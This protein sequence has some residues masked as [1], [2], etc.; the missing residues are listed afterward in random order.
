MLKKSLFIL[1]LFFLT[2]CKQKNNEKSPVIATENI[3]ETD[4]ATGFDIRK[5]K[6]YN[7]ITLNTPWKNALK[8][9][10]YLLIDNDAK[11]PKSIVYDEL[12]RVP[13]NKLVVTSTTHIPALESLGVLDKLVGF[14]NTN[15]ISS[16]AARELVKN[17]GIKELGKNESLNLEVLVD[18]NPDVVV[19][20]GIDGSNKALN[21]IKKSGIPVLYN[22]EWLEQHALGR[23]EW[24]KFFGFLFKK[25][26]EANEI[27]NTIKKEYNDAK[28]LAKK[29]V[30][31]PRVLSGMP[32][33]DTWYL[34]YGDSWAAQFI[35]D[36]N[37]S[38]LWSDKNGKGS[39]ALNFESVLEKAKD[40]DY[41]IAIGNYETKKQLLDSNSHYEQ[42]KMFQENTIYISNTKGATGGLLFYE[43]AP[44]RPDLI[45]KDLIKIFH[46]E[47]L[48][49]YNLNFYTQLN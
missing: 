24:I 7:I 21:N 49:K 4:F 15:Y 44:T 9:L 2:N 37:A 3:I 11:I 20:F 29:A 41:W 19:G 10:K 39:L 32:Y 36:A 16:L 8:P 43:L 48:P 33:K 14:P 28:K 38:Y 46:P 17:G 31:Q 5:E 30:I 42:F 35:N 13:V 45:L 6:G 23:A 25:E 22:S 34:P 27:F 47:L 12:I 18:L 26:K 40:A 1:L